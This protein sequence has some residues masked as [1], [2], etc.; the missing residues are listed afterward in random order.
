[1]YYILKFEVQIRAILL[2]KMNDIN[3]TIIIG[4]QSK[5]NKFLNL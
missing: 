5:T 2:S 1:M 4:K 3:C